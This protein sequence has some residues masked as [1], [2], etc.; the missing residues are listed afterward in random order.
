[1]YKY[2]AAELLRF[3]MA[4]HFE[5]NPGSKLGLL[6][7]AATSLKLPDNPEELAKDMRRYREFANQF[8]MSFMELYILNE[9]VRFLHKDDRQIFLRNPELFIPNFSIVSELGRVIERYRSGELNRLSE[10]IKISDSEAEQISFKN[11]IGDRSFSNLELAAIGQLTPRA[12]KL[13]NVLPSILI[14]AAGRTLT[15]IYSESFNA[16]NT[17]PAFK[18]TMVAATEEAVLEHGMTEIFIRKLTE[19]GSDRKLTRR[20]LK[21]QVDWRKQLRG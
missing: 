5:K 12:E 16:V 7:I 15:A 1:M 19:P 14:Q 8:G 11:R 2:S 18:I 4:E 10:T 13:K 3:R 21:Q 20:F 6:A 9:T 17:S